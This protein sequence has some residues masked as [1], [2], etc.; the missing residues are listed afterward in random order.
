MLQP[1]KDVTEDKDPELINQLTKK[2]G[3][4]HEYIGDLMA[5]SDKLK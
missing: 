1:M 2:L 5:V 4:S 3:V